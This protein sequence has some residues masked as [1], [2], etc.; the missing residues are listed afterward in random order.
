[1]QVLESVVAN[2]SSPV[3]NDSSIVYPNTYDGS[4]F[5]YPTGVVDTV[6]VNDSPGTY[7][8]EWATTANM[9]FDATMYLMWR[10]S[11]NVVGSDNTVFVPLRAYHWPWSA[12]ATNSTATMNSDGT[13]TNN[14]TG[15]SV[16]SPSYPPHTNDASAD[17]NWI[18]EPIWNTNAPDGTIIG[19]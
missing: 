11:T 12:S 6:S 10:P 3:T 7:L 8:P 17:T 18:T 14:G 13:W 1:M 4:D 15:W 5:P 16:V 2:Q 19:T 9:Y